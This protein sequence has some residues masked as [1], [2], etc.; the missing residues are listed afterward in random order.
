MYI[1]K[2]AARLPWGMALGQHANGSGV[3]LGSTVE[4][5][6]RNTVTVFKMSKLKVMMEHQFSA[7]AFRSSHLGRGVRCGMLWHLPIAVASPGGIGTGR[8]S[9]PCA[10]AR[11]CMRVV[12]M[13]STHALICLKQTPTFTKHTCLR[14]RVHAAIQ[15]ICYTLGSCSCHVTDVVQL[16]FHN[17]AVGPTGLGIICV[18]VSEVGELCYRMT[19]CLLIEYVR[20]LSLLGKAWRHEHSSHRRHGACIQQRASL[21]LV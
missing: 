15:F 9:E 18:G 21:R 16:C 5:E 7:L 20:F 17:L 8:T 4:L 3:V 6:E 14:M 13:L 12:N 1:T 2:G 11:A 10:Q 19:S